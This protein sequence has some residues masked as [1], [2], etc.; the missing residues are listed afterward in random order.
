MYYQ[1]GTKVVEE[2]LGNPWGNNVIATCQ[3][4]RYAHLIAGLLNKVIIKE[5]DKPGYLTEPGNSPEPRQKAAS[6]R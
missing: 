5:S 4:K 3:D 2:R 1:E 6:V